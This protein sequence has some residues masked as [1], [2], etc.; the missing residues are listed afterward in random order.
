MTDLVYFSEFYKRY[1]NLE[2]IIKD[3]DLEIINSLIKASKPNDIFIYSTWFEV[4]E[5]LKNLISKNPKRAVVYSGMDWHDTGFRK[6]VHEYI[7]SNIEQVTYVGNTDGNGYFSYWLFFIEKYFRTYTLDQVY[8][9]KLDK[10]FMCLNRKRHMH[11]VTLVDKLLNSSL[12][13][14][15]LI[16]LGGNIN[17]GIPPLTLTND[18]TNTE[19]DLA[20][21]DSVE[22]ISNDISSLGNLENWNRSLINLVTE[23]T[24]FSNT[25]IS[26]KTWKPIIGLRPFIIVGDIGVYS[27]LKEYGIDTFDDLFGTG[28]KEED[29]NKRIDWA[30]AALKKYENHNLQDLFNQ[31]LPRLVANKEKMEEIFKV[32]HTRYKKVLKNLGR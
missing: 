29:F 9:K 2:S 8:P 16:T 22:G 15:G 1:L 11:R 14:K 10:L 4:D 24:H 5:D 28:Y 13:N 32:N 6:D 21:G 23:T 20:I 12:K 17:Q 18:I 3:L 7:Q 19:G 31:L 30:V 26:E 25:F 27:H